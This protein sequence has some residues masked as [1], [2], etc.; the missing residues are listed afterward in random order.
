MVMGGP[1]G[2][3][4]WLDM[5]YWDWAFGVKVSLLLMVMSGAGA[6]VGGGDG[7][8]GEVVVIWEPAALVLVRM[9]AGRWVVEVWLAPWASV[10]VMVVG[11]DAETE[12]V[13]RLVEKTTLP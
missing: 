7:L 6:L 3:R 10:E 2:V 11:K 5:M 4:V 9:I 1:F 8:R 13:E 12:A